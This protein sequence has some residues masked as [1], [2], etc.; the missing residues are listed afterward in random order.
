MYCSNCGKPV[1]EDANF[2]KH[3]GTI[4]REQSKQQSSSYNKSLYRR[5]IALPYKWQVAILCYIFWV[6]GWICAVIIVGIE[7]CDSDFEY[8]LLWAFIS[9]FIIPFL[10]FAF[11]HIKNIHKANKTPIETKCA[12]ARESA[13]EGKVNHTKSLI[14]PKIT[15]GRE[16][17]RFSLQ[18]FSFLYGKMQVKVI[19]KE[20]NSIESYC[21]FTNNGIETKVV[22]D[23]KLGSL[24]AA[25]VSAR[26]T[27]LCVVEYEG[28]HYVLSNK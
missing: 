20:D 21:T 2:C 10:L 18:E 22:F 4:I 19:K 6:L 8:A 14:V 12:E 23:E 13:I 1:E 7:C 26:K 27:G 15:I 24:S 25:E 3:C 11:Y 9:I 16:V 28:K 5:Y 17:D